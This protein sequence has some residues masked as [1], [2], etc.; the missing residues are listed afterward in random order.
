MCFEGPSVSGC[1]I[2]S[3]VFDRLTVPL[4][5]LLVEFLADEPTWLV[6]FTSVAQLGWSPT[7]VI[8]VVGST[9]CQ[10]PLTGGQTR[11]PTPQCHL[12]KEMEWFQAHTNAGTW[13]VLKICSAL[14]DMLQWRMHLDRVVTPSHMTTLD[15]HAISG[16][17]HCMCVVGSQHMCVGL[18]AALGVCLGLRKML[19]IGACMEYTWLWEQTWHRK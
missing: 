11:W 7:D 14:S 12:L 3:C 6:P 1:M 19:E 2:L 10:L 13:L 18:D 4:P 9:P 17:V 5:G 8:K 16:H 15:T